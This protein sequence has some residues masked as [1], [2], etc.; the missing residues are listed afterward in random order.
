MATGLGACVPVNDNAEDDGKR[1][2]GQ[3]AQHDHR[4][5]PP[6][7]IAVMACRR[8]RRADRM[9]DHCAPYLSKVWTGVGSTRL[10]GSGRVSDA[11][12][13]ADRCPYRPTHWVQRASKPRAITGM[14][15][16]SHTQPRCNTTSGR[17]LQHRRVAAEGPQCLRTL[18]CTTARPTAPPGTVS[19]STVQLAP[20]HGA[21]HLH[22]GLH[23]RRGW[24][25]RRL[26]AIHGRRQLQNMRSHAAFATSLHVLLQ[27]PTTAQLAARNLDFMHSISERDI[28]TSSQ[29]W[30]IA[31]TDAS[32]RVW[33]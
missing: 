32:R 14:M 30:T 33:T 3:R 24:I 2:D 12:A 11:A 9:L 8:L 17:A 25:E 31:V 6:W 10:D 5:C 13:S 15:S 4:D 26:G 1:N 27:D 22:T 21:T 19:L 28:D 16:M 18:T 29:A 20:I 7:Q 23:L